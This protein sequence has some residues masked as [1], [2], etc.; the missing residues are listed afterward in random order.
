MTVAKNTVVAIEYELRDAEGIVLDSNKNFAPLEYLHGAGN[1]VAGLEK[2]LQGLQTNDNIQVIVSPEFGYGLHDNTLLYKVP[3]TTYSNTGFTA[4]GDIIQLPDGKEAIIIA[5]DDN[6]I[7][8]D[9][10]HPLAGRVLHYDVTIKNIREA[11][12]EEI[13]RDQPLEELNHCSGM[14]GC[15]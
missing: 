12:N 13:E 8:A 11:S 14:P 1:I 2:A 3:L 7:L 10:N 6:S 5:V 9:A 4:I 15:C